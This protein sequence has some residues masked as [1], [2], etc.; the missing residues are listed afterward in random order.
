MGSMGNAKPLLNATAS[1]LD[2]PAYDVSCVEDSK[3]EVRPEQ[4]APARTV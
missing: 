1:V 3:Y 2:D 4:T